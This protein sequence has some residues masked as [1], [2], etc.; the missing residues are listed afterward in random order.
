MRDYA[1][2]IFLG[3]TPREARSYL[4]RLMSRL[5]ETTA[6]NRVVVPCAGQFTGPLAALQAGFSPSQIETSDVS[7][8]SA[9]IGTLAS[10]GDPRDLGITVDLSDFDDLGKLVAKTSSGIEYAA[11]V[12]YALKE[13]T[14]PTKHAKDMMV[15][16]DLH[17]RRV[18]HVAFLA[19]HLKTL[20]ERLSGIQYASRDLF[21]VVGEAKDDP[22]AI[23]YVD[24]PGYK[25]GYEKMFASE[26]VTWGAAPKY[27]LFAPKTG[28]DEVMES[29]KDSPVPPVS[30]KSSSFSLND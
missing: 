20:V 29:V 18:A 11:L 19:K 27:G 4:V 3:S 6:F 13:G 30:G 16:N 24:P 8:F 25:G 28:F 2:T 21:D 22:R 12:M 26:R 7:V 23:L 14:S 1:P 15:V 10:G 9:M 5:R 17:Q